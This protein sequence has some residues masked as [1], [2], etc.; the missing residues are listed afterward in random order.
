MHIPHEINDIS[1]FDQEIK[2]IFEEKVKYSVVNG[3]EYDDSINDGFKNLLNGINVIN[4]F[5]G[6]TEIDFGSRT[7][8]YNE[9]LTNIKLICD[10]FDQVVRQLESRK[11]GFKINNEYDVQNI[12]H[13]LLTLYFDDI[14]REEYIPSSGGANSR[15]D[16]LLKPEQILIEIKKT[17]STHTNKKLGEELIINIDRYPNHPDCKNLVFFIYDPDRIIKN[18]R[19]FENDFENR[20]KNINIKVFIRPE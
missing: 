9:S 15:V 18:P 5:I 6:N 14:R 10:K 7:S 3:I 13:S 16:F 11:N 19:G 8:D 12:F 20:T 17:R 2:E 4:N 1:D